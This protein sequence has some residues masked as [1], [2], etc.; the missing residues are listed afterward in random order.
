MERYKKVEK[1]GLANVREGRK[2]R[3]RKCGKSRKGRRGKRGIGEKGG[4]EK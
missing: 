3:G 2:G 4:V 1:G